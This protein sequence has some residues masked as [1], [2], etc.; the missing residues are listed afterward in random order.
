MFP[1]LWAHSV[2]P[3]GRLFSTPD[4]VYP[5]SGFCIQ[6]SESQLP[7]KPIKDAVDAHQMCSSKIDAGTAYN[8]LP[9]GAALRVVKRWRHP[10]LF[11]E[12]TITQSFQNKNRWVGEKYHLSQVTDFI[13]R[14]HPQTPEHLSNQLPLKLHKLVRSHFSVLSCLRGWCVWLGLSPVSALSECKDT[15]TCFGNTALGG[16]QREP[17]PKRG[18]WSENSADIGGGPRQ[19]EGYSSAIRSAEDLLNITRGDPSVQPIGVCSDWVSRTA[20]R[21]MMCPSPKAGV[22]CMWN[23]S[24]GQLS[25]RGGHVPWS[26]ERQ[27]RTPW[28]Q[29]A[30]VM[31]GKARRAPRQRRL[32][33][34]HGRLKQCWRQ[35]CRCFW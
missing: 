1:H 15:G 24:F 21:W 11:H 17:S 33:R 34:E 9:H 30:S 32:C 12:A 19:P 31:D 20:F 8:Q 35:M 2:G 22:S 27:K 10:I 6:Y 23:A 16:V 28:P 4:H 13:S 25:W 14:S 26:R 5:S 7:D 18:G 29:E 3:G